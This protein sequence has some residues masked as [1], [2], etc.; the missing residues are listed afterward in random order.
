VWDL[1]ENITTKEE[2]IGFTPIFDWSKNDFNFNIPVAYT[3]RDDTYSISDV[4]KKFDKLDFSREDFAKVKGL[5]N[6]VSKRYEL[7]IHYLGVGANYSNVDVSLFLYGN[8]I[9]G[10]MTANRKTAIAAG[11]Q[12]NEMICQVEFDSGFKV[13]GFGAVSFVSGT[14]GG[15]T[16]FQMTETQVYPDDDSVSDEAVGK[17]RFNIMLCASASGGDEFNAYFTFPA[18]IDLTKFEE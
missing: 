9:R 14:N 16:N 2:Y 4:A 3:D 6:A 13:T 10:Y 5:F 15:I 7:P 1:L 11:N 18:L 8:T 17:G 12:A